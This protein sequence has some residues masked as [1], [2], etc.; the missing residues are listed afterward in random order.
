MNRRRSRRERA[1]AQRTAQLHVLET[2]PKK[3]N[4]FLNEKQIKNKI[5]IAK[6]DI[7]N[8]NRKLQGVR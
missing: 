8:L 2:E 1:L 7:K 6:Q 4:Q 3:A 5:A